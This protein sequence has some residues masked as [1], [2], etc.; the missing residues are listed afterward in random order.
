MNEVIADTD[1]VPHLRLNPSF[2]ANDIET[3]SDGY[4]EI[5]PHS[6]THEQNVV[7][8]NYCKEHGLGDDITD[9]GDVTVLSDTVDVIVCEQ[10]DVEQFTD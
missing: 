7:H 4:Y 9:E 8:A 2:L 6:F 10:K 1:I 3:L 5:K